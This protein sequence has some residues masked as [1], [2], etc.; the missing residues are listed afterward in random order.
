MGLLQQTFTTS[1]LAHIGKAV[2]ALALKSDQIF[3]SII[4]NF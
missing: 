3:F 1:Q 4:L 2:N